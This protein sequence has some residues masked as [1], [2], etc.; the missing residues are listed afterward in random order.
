[1]DPIRCQEIVYRAITKPGWIDPGTNRINAT[2]FILFEKDRA[3]GLSVF[4]KSAVSDLGAL[5]ADRFNRSF[6]ADTL[7]VGRVRTLSLD[8]CRDPDDPDAAH[9]VI[10]G[11]PWPD[12]DPGLAES[13]ASALRD[14]S[15]AAD[16]TKRKKLSG[17]NGA[18]F[19][20]AAFVEHAFRC[21]V[22]RHF[23]RRGFGRGGWRRVRRWG[24]AGRVGRRRLWLGWL[25]G[26]GW[27]GCWM[28]P[29]RGLW[30]RSL[31]LC[32]RSW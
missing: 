25:G 11:L 9:C 29:G 18:E 24:L 22:R 26:G 10:T 32:G 4:M 30:P 31:R 21:A 16:R 28:L 6:G 13:L 8:V 23:V 3:D 5:L 20:T 1:M 7:H 17:G 19:R 15:R 2:A 27:R 14:M 12:D